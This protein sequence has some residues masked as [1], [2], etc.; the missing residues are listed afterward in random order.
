MS[1]LRSLHPDGRHLVVPE[2][3]TGARERWD[4]DACA[5]F[6]R[7]PAALVELEAFDEAVDRALRDTPRH[8]P[9]LDARL[10][11][12]V[13]RA[14][15]LSRRDAADPGV[16]R[17]L[18]VVHRPDLIRHRWEARS[19]PTMRSRF[20]RPGTR[21]DS[22]TVARLYWIAELSRVGDDYSRTERLLARQP[23][24][25][26]LFTRELC[27]Y[28]PLVEAWLDVLEEAPGPLLERCVRDLS[29]RLST[30][31]LEALSA[32]D[33]RETLREILARD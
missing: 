4:P 27:A 2:L 18:T 3:A 20:W 12:A 13:H 6:L 31:V 26:N 17:Y 30:V 16:F 9:A 22:N 25:N 5:A 23:L 7:D 14:L 10:A 15:A 28:G 8:D 19:W 29:R 21:P 11:P 33:L 1:V 32:D 24:V